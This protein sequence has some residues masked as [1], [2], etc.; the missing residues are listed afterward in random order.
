MLG[1]SQRGIAGKIGQLVDGYMAMGETGMSGMQEMQMPLPENTLP[2]MAGDGPF[3]ALEMGGMFT[4]V[5]VREGLAHDDYHDSGWYAHPAG[6]VAW[7]AKDG[8]K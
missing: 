8:L 7:E 4:V 3:G 1:V 2:M 6:T 5:K